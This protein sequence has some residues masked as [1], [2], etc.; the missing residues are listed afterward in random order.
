[1]K[2]I[3]LIL[4][5]A[6]TLVFIS[7]ADANDEKFI[8]AMQKNIKS[9]YEAKE[10]STLQQSVNS[11]ERIAASEKNKWEPFYYIGFGYLMMANIETDGNKKDTYL[12]K[13]LEAI[14]KGKGITPSESELIALE[15]F[16]YMLKVSV[17]PQSRGMVLA[18][19]AVQTFEAALVLNPENPR[20]L[21]LL[22]QMQFGTAQFFG[23]PP[24]DACS[25]N[26]KALEKF[27]TYK[28]ENPLAPVWGLR[29]AESLKEACK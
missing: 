25:S 20:A 16:V 4:V 7:Q 14:E 23:S 18:P 26:T 19:K 1:M 21:A 12:D 13:A 11:F 24:T 6:A 17:D 5:A 27:Q 3:K 9:V 29:M 2:N 28:S 15:G 8:E 22:A 10:I